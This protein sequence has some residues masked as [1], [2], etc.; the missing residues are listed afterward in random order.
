MSFVHQELQYL[1]HVSYH[2]LKVKNHF[3]LK[4]SLIWY[5]KLSNLSHSI[6]EIWNYFD[7][8]VLLLTLLLS[9]WTK[10]CLSFFFYVIKYLSTI[11]FMWPQIDSFNFVVTFSIMSYW[12]LILIFDIKPYMNS[13]SKNTPCWNI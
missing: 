5:S 3:S 2:Q 6:F 9:I 10:N 1:Y 11:Y 7:Y 4:S 8:F 13:N 12:C